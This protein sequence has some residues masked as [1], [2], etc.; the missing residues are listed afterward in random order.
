MHKKTLLIIKNLGFTEDLVETIKEE[1]KISGGSINRKII[2]WL[3]DA[4]TPDG[5]LNQ[6]RSLELKSPTK[7]KKTNKQLIQNLITKCKKIFY[8]FAK[9]GLKA[10]FIFRNGRWGVQANVKDATVTAIVKACEQYF[11]FYASK[12]INVVI[13]FTGSPEWEVETKKQKDL[14]DN[15]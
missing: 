11:N 2:N 5:A 12:K 7:N 13:R 3:K 14:P 10:T 8:D 4:G 9:T 15:I 1:S 6:I